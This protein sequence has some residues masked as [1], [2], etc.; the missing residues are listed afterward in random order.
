[1][2]RIKLETFF[3]ILIIVAFTLAAFQ[4]VN[5]L[6]GVYDKSNSEIQVSL[7]ENI[8]SIRQGTVHLKNEQL[9]SLLEAVT[10]NDAEKVVIDVQLKIIWVLLFLVFCLSIGLV[11]T[12]QK[13]RIRKNNET[14][15]EL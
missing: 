14:D 11:L 2:K 13:L 7:S 6:L 8:N 3:A 4:A 12:L 10:M 15:S 9:A 1:M 5:Y